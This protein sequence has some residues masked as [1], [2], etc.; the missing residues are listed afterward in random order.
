MAVVKKSEV[1]EYVIDLV[2]SA[3]NAFYLLAT[4]NKL[5]KQCGLNP[6]KLMDEMKSGDYI[7]LLKV[8]DKHFGHF[9]KFE[10]SN[11]EYLKAFN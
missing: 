10:T 7:E 9:I 5:A 11:E 2:S 8:M 3:G 6:F 4:S 1:R